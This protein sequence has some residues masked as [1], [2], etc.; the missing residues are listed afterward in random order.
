MIYPIYV[1]GMPVLRKVAQDIDE[2]YEGLA[3]LIER[4]YLPHYL[5]RQQPE[6]Q[7]LILRMARELG[8][9]VFRRQTAALADRPDAS[10]TLNSLHCPTLIVGSAGDPLCPPEVQWE[11]HRLVRGSDLLLLGDCG[12]FSTLER[13]DALSA[14]LCSW[15]LGE[16]V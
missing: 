4:D 10:A 3:Q 13:P 6:H 9:A 1:Y 8:A 12:H 15:Y 2:D 11:M 16:A 7:A 5:Q 14:A